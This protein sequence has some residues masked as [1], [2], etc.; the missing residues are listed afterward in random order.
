VAAHADAEE[1]ALWAA[2]VA[3]EEG[4]SLLRRQAT[5]SGASQAERLIAEA[6]IRQGNAKTIRDILGEL[7]EDIL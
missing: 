1:R 2:V 4:A 6:D 3:L 7:T 5:Q